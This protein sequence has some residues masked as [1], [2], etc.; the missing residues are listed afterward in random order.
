M[1][2][3]RPPQTV[4]PVSRV[5]R[6]GSPGKRLFIPGTLPSLLSESL[7]STQQVDTGNIDVANNG[8]S[9]PKP[10][11]E[12]AVF[13]RVALLA[14]YRP[15]E[16][17]VATAPSAEVV[18]ATQSIKKDPIPGLSTTEPSTSALGSQSTVI[19]PKPKKATSKKY[20]KKRKS[21]GQDVYKPD[22]D[23]NDDTEP[24]TTIR[25][26]KRTSPKNKNKQGRQS[27][28]HRQSLKVAT[29]RARTGRTSIRRESKQLRKLR[30]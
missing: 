18:T 26:K 4:S 6:S 28:L 21:G 15:S 5:C 9:E 17:S 25:K 19:T 14:K 27:G 2:L 8:R 29:R 7:L 16:T 20:T 22:M 23:S 11:I 3:P 10:A 24:P 1:S 13:L 30:L 12:A